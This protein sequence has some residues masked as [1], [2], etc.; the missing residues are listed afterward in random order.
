MQLIDLKRRIQRL[1]RLVKGLAKEIALWRGEEGL[2]R[3][4]EKRQYLTSIQKALSGAEA[5]RVVLV[6]VV[7]RIEGVRPTGQLPQ[8]P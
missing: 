6:G 1:E 7:R 4:G 8:R 5:A 2:L 3:F